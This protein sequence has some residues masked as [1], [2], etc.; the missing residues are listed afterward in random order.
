M[1]HDGIGKLAY[2]FATFGGLGKLFEN[3]MPGTIA[4][5]VALIIRWKIDLGFFPIVVLFFIGVWA[6]HVYSK[7]LRDDDPPCVVIDEVVGYFVAMY[8][9]S[10]IMLLPSFFFFRILDIVKPFPVRAFEKLPGGWGIM[11]DDVIA[12]I[13]SNV[14]ISLGVWFWGLQR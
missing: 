5:A 2:Y 14:L 13:V 1:G 4:T 9:F 3:R 6:S 12:G 11:M 10:D 8:G 7:A